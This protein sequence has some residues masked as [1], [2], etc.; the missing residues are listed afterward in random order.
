MISTTYKNN[1]INNTINVNSSD[2]I[3]FNTNFQYQGNGKHNY[4][5]TIFW[6]FE[7]I[8]FYANNKKYDSYP[9]NFKNNNYNENIEF[10][11]DKRFENKVHTLL[12]VVKDSEY[13]SKIITELTTPYK[14]IVTDSSKEI[15]YESK[16]PLKAYK[17]KL[18]YLNVVNGDFIDDEEKYKNSEN[19]YEEK[20]LEVSPNTEIELAVR[21][22]NFVNNG[23]QLLLLELNN[24]QLSIDNKPFIVYDLNP[25]IGFIY[26]KIRIITPSEPGEYRLES[27]VITN[28]NSELYNDVLTPFFPYKLIVK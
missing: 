26:D 4:E 14:F 1:I 12:I 21:F 10:K 28:P 8:E 27:T 9:I 19:F 17:S 18:E 22:K 24:K 15:S 3:K 7:Q 13:D 11:L 16:I 23:T 20:T 2:E 25:N 5:L 6:D